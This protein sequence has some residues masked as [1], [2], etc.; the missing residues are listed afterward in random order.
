M[1]N[2]CLATVTVK[3]NIN[4]VDEF[5]KI[6]QADYNY[7]TMKFTHKPHFFR[8]FE[9]PI[10]DE[11]IDGLIKTTT[12]LIECAW[13]VSVCM[14]SGPF[15]YYDECKTE[16]KEF[17]AT[18]LQI[19]AR[20]L[21]LFIEIFSEEPGIGFNE[22]IMYNNFGM[23]FKNDCLDMHIYDLNEY[24]SREDFMNQTKDYISEEDYKDSLE[25]DEGYYACDTIEY[26][27]FINKIEY[28][29]NPIAIKVIK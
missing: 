13:S 8:I 23:R 11:E 29:I 6:I 26:K 10:I 21:N 4:N 18:N 20:N 16:F 9:T 28:A 19:C 2:I 12:Y 14:E 3:G 7:D 1:P 25:Y 22:Y 24:K 15:S 5:T 27:P 17:Y